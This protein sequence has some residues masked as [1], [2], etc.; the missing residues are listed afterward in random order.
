MTTY[1]PETLE[2][3]WE[4]KLSAEDLRILQSHFKD[5]NRFQ[6]FLKFCQDRVPWPDPILLPLQPHLFVVQRPDSERVIRCDCGHE[7]CN[8]KKNWKLEA[9]IHVRDSDASLQELYPP[10]MH[11]DPA[12]M[13]VREFYCPGCFSLLEVELAPPGYPILHDF[14]PDLDVFWRDWLKLKIPGPCSQEGG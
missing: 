13:E 14:Q 3:L 4:G 5:R 1:D 7:F 12:W 2:K 8:V 10:L 9:R 11:C 6:S